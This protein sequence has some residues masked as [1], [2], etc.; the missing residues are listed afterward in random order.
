MNYRKKFLIQVDTDSESLDSDFIDAHFESWIDENNPSNFRSISKQELTKAFQ[1]ECI[2]W[3]N[4]LGIGIE[5][6]WEES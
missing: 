1:S 2:S 5:F 3:L 4:D 6:L